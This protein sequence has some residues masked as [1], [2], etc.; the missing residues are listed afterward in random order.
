[1]HIQR[2]STEPVIQLHFY[3]VLVSLRCVLTLRSL[4]GTQDVN[5]LHRTDHVAEDNRRG[6]SQ[7]ASRQGRGCYPL[8][9]DVLSHNKFEKPKR[10]EAS[11]G[12]ISKSDL[13][14]TYTIRKKR[15]CFAQK[16]CCC[17]LIFTRFDHIGEFTY[18]ERSLGR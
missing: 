11:S 1:M 7:N 2:P 9:G 15:T 6:V 17:E 18:L 8:L 14:L 5:L 13:R 12:N 10:T 3:K 16:P 4:P